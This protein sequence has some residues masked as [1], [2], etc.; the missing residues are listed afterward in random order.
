PPLSRNLAPGGRAVLSGLM[1]SQAPQVLEA[2]RRTGLAREAEHRLGDW[3]VLILRKARA[4]TPPAAR[5]NPA[6][7]SSA[8]PESQGQG[9]ARAGR[10]SRGRPAAPA[11]PRGKAAGRRR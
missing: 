6:T 2:Y 1:T 10:T 7:G 9:K 11:A 5:P 3:S 4:A 8:R